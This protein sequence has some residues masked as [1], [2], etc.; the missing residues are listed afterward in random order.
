MITDKV[1]SSL[2]FDKILQR[3]S[4]YAVLS[5]SKEEILQL[6][7]FDN[8]NLV[9]YML[10]KTEEAFN[11]QYFFG[12]SGVDYFDDVTEELELSE[13]GATLSMAQLL[14][15]AALLRSSRLVKTF[16]SSVTDENIKIFKDE[17][18]RIYFDNGL[19]K[20]I[21]SK[22]LSDEQMA[23]NASE[24]LYQIRRKIKNLNIQIKEKLQYYIRSKASFLQDNIVTIRE[25]RYVIP[26]KSEHKTKI[27]GFI[28]D[29]SATGSTFF[30]EP[31]EVLEMN[32]QLKSAYI[33]EENEI[34]R[35]LSELSANV[36][37]IAQMLS[38]NIA[39]LTQ[40]DVA[41]A[42]A[43]Y[44]YKTKA[45]KPL[46]N[47]SGNIS[48]KD[49]K[50][51]L[52][53]PLKVVPIN[54]GLGLRYNFLLISGPNT[55]GKTV[56]LKLVGLF[57]VM[58]MS[59]IFIQADKQSCISV[60]ERIFTDIGDEQSIENSLSTFSSHLTNIIN[61]CENCNSSS[62][63]LLDE[64]GGGTNPDEGI[65]IA[66]AV[67]DRL[68]ERG[69]FGIVT[70]HYTALKEYAFETDL[71]S[72][73]SMEFD[74]KS[75]QPL[76][77]INIGSPGSSNALA[78]AQRLGL[79]NELIEKARGYLSDSAR[80]YEQIINNA[81]EERRRA[82]I[83]YSKNLENQVKSKEILDNLVLEREEFYKEKERFLA[84]S[85]AEGRR[86]IGEKVDEANELIDEIKSILDKRE[87][88]TGD[89]IR[90]RTLKNQLE[91]KA[92]FYEE[93]ENFVRERAENIKVGQVVFVEQI[94]K[95]AVVEKILKNQNKAIVKSGV[96][97]LTLPLENLSVGKKEKATVEINIKRPD[98]VNAQPFNCEINLI[99]QTVDE[100]LGNLSYFIDKAL[101]N[102]VNE[103]RII[104][105]VGLKKL[106]T[107]IHSYLKTLNYIDT[108]RFGKYGEGEN[109][110]TIVTFK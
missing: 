11:L 90:A 66:K 63:V 81:E 31:I 68:I 9:N 86:I 27:N 23:D 95:N 43:T 47:N 57:C 108:Y 20:E 54:V 109:G 45:I 22:I 59:G 70:T 26:V 3:I 34:E 82:E 56:T 42:K 33:E 36:G 72:N 105:G 100:A 18:E 10:N 32:N 69:A 76:Y 46:V 65:A 19:E 25:N 62:L 24:L 79:D 74:A 93:K 5:Y 38:V 104:H 39:I 49:G 89:L 1:L 73:A 91:N 84:S 30:I 40:A 28:H 88:D 110:V 21:T 94:G 37:A 17:T 52:I 16:I 85:R 103:V 83:E 15:I 102:N 64:L 51:P 99:G 8:L 67:F 97:R 77:K 41:C 29:Q 60:F 78:V 75:L 35:I 13:R 92:Y 58:A 48:I 2:Q 4:E 53:D 106:S 14:K 101:L 71:I 12:F 44:A 96:I 61:I 7:P 87:I 50:H 80:R 55:G 98:R 6:K 107:A